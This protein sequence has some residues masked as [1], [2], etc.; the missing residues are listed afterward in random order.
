MS[1]P[2]AKSRFA[3]L[4]AFVATSQR[5][6]DCKTCRWLRTAPV[7]DADF[8]RTLLNAPV[9]VKGHKHISQVLAAGGVQIS[10]DAVRNHRSHHLSS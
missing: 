10:E 4:D 2:A 1:K 9:E 6:S 8:I 5:P 3:E 7:E